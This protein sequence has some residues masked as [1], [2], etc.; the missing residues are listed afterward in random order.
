ATAGTGTTTGTAT[1]AGAVATTGTTTT[2]G[3]V[4]T[5]GTI[6]LA[7]ACILR[8]RTVQQ[9]HTLRRVLHTREIRL[10]EGG[11]EIVGEVVAAVLRIRIRRHDFLGL[12]QPMRRVIE[13]FAHLDDRGEQ[14][15]HILL[16]GGDGIGRTLRT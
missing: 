8:D 10:L 5:T 1:T 3:T 6:A 9:R 15:F 4:A 11:A 16:V 13:Q 12:V 14:R 2:T 7:A